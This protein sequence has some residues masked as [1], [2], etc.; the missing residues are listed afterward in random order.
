[1]P[2]KTHQRQCLLILSDVV[3]R[4]LCWRERTA[5]LGAFPATHPRRTEQCRL[6]AP[7][8]NRIRTDS[9]SPDGDASD[10]VDSVI[11]G[12]LK[13]IVLAD[14]P[15]RSRPALRLAIVV[16]FLNEARFLP[17]LL[18]SLERQTEPADQV[19][20]VDDGSTDGSSAIAEAFAASREDFRVLR[21]PNRPSDN[22]RLV[23]APELRAFMWGVARLKDDWDVVAKM[24]G[25]LQ[26]AQSL[27]ADVRRE[28]KQDSRL[29]ITGSCLI[30]IDD[31]QQAHLE[32]NPTYHVRGPNK[33]YLREC[34]SQITPMPYCLGWDTIDDLRARRAGWGTRSFRPTSGETIHL[35]PTGTHDGR[36]RAY[37]RWGECAWGYGAHPLWVLLGALRRATR[38]PYVIAGANYLWGWLAAAAR[39]R[40]RAEPDLIAFCR[41]EDMHRIDAAFRKAVPGM[42]GR[43][44]H[45]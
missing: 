38:E 10:S 42:I 16:S 11:L 30:A 15:P 6:G 12:E 3:L 18:E 2:S 26:L 8:E 45:E 17:R 37:R 22:D 43:R 34:F 13:A 14:A 20:L 5:S 21:R 44:R 9:M 27:C 36:L 32:R 39:R 33:F 41:L 19:L 31:Q 7:C 28:F 35:R 25:D 1:M 29:G 23:D 4:T 40:P 24:D